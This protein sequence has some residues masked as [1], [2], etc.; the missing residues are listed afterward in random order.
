[1]AKSHSIRITNF[2]LIDMGGWL[3]VKEEGDKK[4]L[5]AGQ[6]AGSQ[7]FLPQLE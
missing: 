5:L 4:W 1:M 2:L 7:S 3:A 6:L